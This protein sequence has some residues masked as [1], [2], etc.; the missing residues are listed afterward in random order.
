[1]VPK[2]HLGSSALLLPALC[3]VSLSP[4]R[5]AGKCQ[6]VS[7][8]PPTPALCPDLLSAAPGGQPAPTCSPAP[9]AASWAVPWRRGKRPPW[10]TLQTEWSR[11]GRNKQDETHKRVG[12]AWRAVFSLTGTVTRSFG[13]GVGRGSPG[14]S[15]HILCPWQV[16]SRQQLVALRGSEG[17]SRKALGLQKG[18]TQHGGGSGWGWDSMPDVLRNC[19]VTVGLLSESLLPPLAGVGG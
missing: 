5:L 9:M 16:A 3:Q 1:M 10:Q 6:Q 14:E 17:C 8:H 13:A 12:T 7:L 11:S 18:P 15:L 2:M 19:C 4:W